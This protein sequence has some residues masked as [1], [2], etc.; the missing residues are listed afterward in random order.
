M[1]TIILQNITVFTDVNGNVTL[2]KDNTTGKFVK[3]KLANEILNSSLV[4]CDNVDKRAMELSDALMYSYQLILGFLVLCATFISNI[5]KHCSMKLLIVF[6]S[7]V[8][9]TLR[10]FVS[11]FKYVYKTSWLDKSLII[12]SIVLI[13]LSFVI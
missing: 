12:S 13:T 1:T 8:T 7:M 4:I 6:Y 10:M 5:I 11:F 9:T 3:L 2:A